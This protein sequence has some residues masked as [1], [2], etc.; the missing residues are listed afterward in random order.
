[1][2]PAEGPASPTSAAPLCCCRLAKASCPCQQAT[3]RLHRW[4]CKTAHALPLRAGHSCAAVLAAARLAPLLPAPCL[5]PAFACAA[6]AAALLLPP[7]VLLGLLE[8]PVTALLPLRLHV[9]P[10]SCCQQAIYRES[11]WH[12]KPAPALPLRASP[13]CAAMF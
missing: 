12:C 5:L 10:F 13:P 1:M 9:L 6:A 3:R 8:P 4:H 7:A 2:A 11:C